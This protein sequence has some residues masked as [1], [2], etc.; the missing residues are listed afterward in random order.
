M[1]PDSDPAPG[2]GLNRR[3]SPL[4]GRSSGVEQQPCQGWGRGF[5]SLRPLRFPAVNLS[6]RSLRVPL[7]SDGACTGADR[8]A[9][10][11]STPR[12]PRRR[13]V[14][15]PDAAATAAGSRPASKKPPSSREARAAPRPGAQGPT[16]PCAQGNAEPAFGRSN[17]PRGRAGRA[18]CARSPCPCRPGFHADRN[19]CATAA[20][21]WSRKGTR[22][23][24]L[25]AIAARSTL[26]KMSS[27]DS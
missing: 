25:T 22:V 9:W 13:R 10:N 16:Q 3:V 6:A 26:H 14:R 17:I 18:I 27:A 21:R 7:R 4:S 5:E 20:T 19:A 23:S 15:P 8:H 24:R 11:I 1:T 12:S 2:V